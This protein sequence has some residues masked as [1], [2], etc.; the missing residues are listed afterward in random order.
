M[1]SKSSTM[2]AVG[3]RV[4]ALK[5][6]REKQKQAEATRKERLVGD[7]KGT[8]TKAGKGAFSYSELWGSKPPGKMPDFEVVSGIRDIAD[9]DERVHGYIPD[10]DET[11][12]AAPLQTAIFTLSM[13]A[14]EKP[15]IFG[16]KGSG[17]ST[18]PKVYAARTNQPFFRIP[19]RRDMEASDLFG[20]PTVRDKRLEFNDGPITLAARYG[21]IVCLD[22]ASVLQAGAA[23]ALQYVLENNGKVI[24][25]DHPSEDPMD[26]MVTPHPAF[27]IVLTDN[28]ALA[29]D[30]TGHYVGT[31]VQNEAFR[32]RI[33]KII[34]LEYL[35]K[36]LEKEMIMRHVPDANH[37]IV[38]EMLTFTSMV[39]TAYE[40][41]EVESATISPRTLIRWARDG[42]LLG[43]YHTAF[44]YGFLNGTSPDDEVVVSGLYRKVFG[45]AP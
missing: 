44:R 9:V 30:H 20:M 2:A 12:V 29:G 40:K 14:N 31:N 43:D 6:Q 28:T 19:C 26:K 8:I 34:K 1:S 39:R 25:P 7:G 37:E 42:V 4:Q 10:D 36:S 41:G 45:V 5:E 35:P 24:L 38:D 16:P 33:D 18:M 17:K 27:R 11:Y 21:G 15:L 13:N 23:L 22:E 3:E 32:D